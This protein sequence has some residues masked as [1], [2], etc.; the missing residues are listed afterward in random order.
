MFRHIT[1]DARG[2][3]DYT[4][5]FAYIDS[6]KERW[7]PTLH[8][9]ASDVARYELQG[10]KTL[11]DA[12]LEEVS[13][14]NTYEEDSNVLLGSTLVLVLRQAFG[15]V[16]SLTYGGVSG[17]TFHGHPERWPDRA[18]DLLMHEFSMEAHGVY[19]HRIAFDRNVSLEI[20]FR[21]FSVEDSPP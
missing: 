7:P 11:H 6:V 5:Y 1:R 15:G 9:F 17:W 12:W 14:R 16:I 2:W 3:S 21:T 13:C 10:T 8:A 20:L 18:I 4:P 19:A